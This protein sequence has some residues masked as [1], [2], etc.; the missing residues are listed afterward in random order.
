[1]AERIV[2]GEGDLSYNLDAS[3]AQE[4][5]FGDVLYL[6]LFMRHEE[7]NLWGLVGG[8]MDNRVGG[9]AEGVVREVEGVV[10]EVEGIDSGSVAGSGV[11]GGGVGWGEHFDGGYQG[12]EECDGFV[13][14]ET[15]VFIAV[16]DGEEEVFSGAEVVEGERAVFVA[17]GHVHGAF[18]GDDAVSDGVGELALVVGEDG[19]G[20]G[21]GGAGEGIENLSADGHAVDGGAGGED[22]FIAGEGV[23]LIVVDNG[24]FELEK[25]GGGG[26][27]RVFYLHQNAV[28]FGFIF[29]FVGQDGGD[30]DIVVGI[31]DVDVLVEFDKEFSGVE[32]GS[33]AGRGG[34]EG[35]GRGLVLG[36]AGREALFGTG[37]ESQKQ[38][39]EEYE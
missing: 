22:V 8:V 16:L 37:D 26:L 14:A 38:D 31:L 39:R 33:A 13:V 17:A 23:A 34:G 9:V 5:A 25:V 10:C 19:D 28:A 27:E 32:V 12:V 36:S 4:T 11:V 3:F 35:D 24:V 20:F 18:F 7:E 30:D 29:G 21:G 1:M 6:F 15:H 2:G